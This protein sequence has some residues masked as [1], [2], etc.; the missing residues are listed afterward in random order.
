MFN[1]HASRFDW[2]FKGNTNYVYVLVKPTIILLR[3]SSRLE[4]E[5]L[6]KYF[7]LILHD[8]KQ[9]FIQLLQIYRN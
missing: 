7:Y 6:S 8:I 5:T 1:N 4:G 3:S 9:K 2:T